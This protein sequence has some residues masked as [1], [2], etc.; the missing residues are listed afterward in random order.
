MRLRGSSAAVTVAPVA[1]RDYSARELAKRWRVSEGKAFEFLR[2]F[3]R[4]GFAERRGGYWRASAR[5]IA[6]HIVDRDGEPWA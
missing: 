3:E 1:V 6:L 4:A 2:D 5:A